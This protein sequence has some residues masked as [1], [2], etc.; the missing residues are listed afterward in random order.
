MKIYSKTTITT[1][2]Y[3]VGTIDRMIIRPLGIKP[4]LKDSLKDKEEEDLQH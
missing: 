2:K 1:K 3:I 4:G